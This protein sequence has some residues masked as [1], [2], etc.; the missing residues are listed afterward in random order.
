MM[1]AAWSTFICEQCH[2]LYG[3]AIGRLSGPGSRIDAADRGSRNAAC[4]KRPAAALNPAHSSAISSRCSSSVRRSVWRSASV[5]QRVLL[6]RRVD[7]ERDLGPAEDRLALGLAQLVGIVDVVG[8]RVVELD[9]RAPGR[10]SAAGG[11]APDDERD[12][13][14]SAEQVE[15]RVVEERLLRDPG[16]DH[17]RARA[18]GAD[19]TGDEPR[20]VAVLPR[21][22]GHRDAVDAREQPGRAAVVAGCLRGFDHEAERVLPG[23]GLAVL[24]GPTDPGDHRRVRVEVTPAFPTRVRRRHPRH[25]VS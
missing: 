20:R 15:V 17:D 7:A 4:G 18:A 5:D 24:F 6:R 13:E 1:A 3:N 23:S 25:P 9:P 10:G 12:V 8:N 19:R 22:L 14:V 16:A 2:L 21:T 11:F